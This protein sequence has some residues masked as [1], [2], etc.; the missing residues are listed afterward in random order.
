LIFPH[1]DARRRQEP[2][3]EKK[4]HLMCFSFVSHGK[5]NVPNIIPSNKHGNGEKKILLPKRVLNIKV[6]S[7]FHDGAFFFPM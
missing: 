4:H 7:F 6:F 5:E 2:E 3:K 1:W